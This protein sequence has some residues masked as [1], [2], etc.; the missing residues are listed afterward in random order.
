MQK[1][2]YICETCQKTVETQGDPE[3]I[4]QCCGGLMK[5]DLPVCTTTETA[6]HARSINSD[7]PCDDGRA[8]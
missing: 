3:D 6:E 5:N 7:E 1:Q 4:P 8:G 2:K